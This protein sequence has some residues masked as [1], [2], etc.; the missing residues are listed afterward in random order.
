MGGRGQ[1][2]PEM[3][4]CLRLEPQWSLDDA[5]GSDEHSWKTYHKCAKTDPSNSSEDRGF[6]SW[7][8]LPDSHPKA[9]VLVEHLG[10]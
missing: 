1:T 6:C 7:D 2:W 10:G 8:P 3:V 5:L 9:P 4:P